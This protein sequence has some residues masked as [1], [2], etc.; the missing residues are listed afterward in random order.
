[1]IHARQSGGPIEA[2]GRLARPLLATVLLAALIAVVVPPLTADAVSHASIRASLT[3]N[4]VEGHGFDASADVN[5]TVAGA[6]PDCALD[7]NPLSTTDG[8][9]SLFVDLNAFAC[10]LQGGTSVSVNVGALTRDLTMIS[11]LTI[12]VDEATGIA[13]GDRPVGFAVRANVGGP[14]CGGE[15]FDND[16]ASPTWSVN[17]FTTPN[18]GGGCQEQGDFGGVDFAQVSVTDADATQ[19]DE[20]VAEPTPPPTIQASITNDW[21]QGGGFDPGDTSVDIIVWADPTETPGTEVLASTSFPTN[22]DGTFFADV[23]GHGVDLA[24]PMRVAVTGQPSGTAKTVNL[25]EPISITVV[26][27]PAGASGELPDDPH[28]IFEVSVG[29]ETCGTGIQF[30]DN[31]ASDQDP[32]VGSWEVDFSGDCPSG[33]GPNVGGH[34]AAIDGEGDSSLAEPVPPPRIRASLDNDWVEG[35][36]FAPNTDVNMTVTGAGP[37]CA[38]LPNPISTTDG[39]GYMFVDLNV[40]SCDLQGG[41]IIN[42]TVGP[43][44]RDLTM[45][46]PL[47]IGVDNGT[48]IASGDRPGGV[49]VRANVGGPVCGGEIFDN[50]PASPTWS[51]DFFTTPNAGGGCAE[52][53][54]FGPDGADFAQVSISDNDA[55]PGD[56]TVAEF[57]PGEPTAFDIGPLPLTGAD[58]LLSAAQG[59]LWFID[60]D[61]LTS[62]PPVVPVGTDP[63]ATGIAGLAGVP[64]PWPGNFDV[65]LIDQNRL[66][67]TRIDAS[68]L[69]E[70]DLLAGN[71]FLVADDEIL[72]APIGVA[73]KHDEPGVYFVAD[74]NGNII[75]YDTNTATGTV[76]QARPGPGA[77][78]IWYRDGVVY[79]TEKTNQFFAHDLATGVLTSVSVGVAGVSFAFN[80]FSFTADGNVLA[81]STFQDPV[82][83]AGA[84]HFDPT[85][86][87]FLGGYTG[88]GGYNGGAGQN[89]CARNVEDVSVL[90]SGLAYWVDSDFEMNFS[91]FEPRL[92][93][94]VVQSNGALDQTDD[95]HTFIG[96]PGLGDIV[97]IVVLTDPPVE[98][99]VPAGGSTN[100]GT[101]PTPSDPVVTSVESPQGGGV[102]ITEASAAGVLEG[103]YELDGQSVDITAPPATNEDPLVLV[104]TIATATPV[105]DIVVLRNGEALTDCPGAVDVPEGIVGCVSGRDTT[106]PDGDAQITVITTDAS[107]WQFAV[108]ACTIEGTSGPDILFGTDGDDV[109]CGFGGDDTIHGRG[110]N[111]LIIAGDGNDTAHGG[112]GADVFFGG[113]GSDEFDGGR[114]P[115][116]AHGGAGNDDLEGGRGTDQLFGEEG[117]DELEGGRGAD[118]LVGGSGNDELE[119]GRGT[120]ELRGGIGDDELEG[121]RGGDI[122]DGG[123][124][125]DECSPGSGTDTVLN[126]EEID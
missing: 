4:W 121:G 34:A 92:C 113:D 99:T 47:T 48:G 103:G 59:V 78:G 13:S 67:L 69:W 109:I 106:V 19:G 29:G 126:C 116:V 80:G 11:P 41:T 89:L 12:N 3:N 76:L 24:E 26:D 39:G 84:I 110:G 57:I 97:D 9:G 88:T 75:E 5:V 87:A 46:S 73:V 38:L 64:L 115:D 51:A 1:M 62:P 102:S 74:E 77:D 112:R 90:T 93:S 54:E 42:V 122:V 7:P 95:S 30:T 23:A 21:V 85:T 111:D 86:G 68:Q 22:G 32:A 65:Q 25:I 101:D 45:A 125:S 104:F 49:E 14:I 114:G 60:R 81:A 50:D 58:V 6:G 10:D 94:A 53:G 36:G 63:E 16:L 118:L 28:A 2:V 31:N 100:T 96:G 117:N 119:G 44:V 108:P 120:D 91:D 43:D 79:F 56:E 82:L 66:I 71:L 83:R 105:E 27:S 15:I 20:A 40:Y 70:L 17:F 33:L 98:E 107:I 123:P 18:A 55:T 8:S 124:D 61:A 35:E 52:Q 72:G 37:D